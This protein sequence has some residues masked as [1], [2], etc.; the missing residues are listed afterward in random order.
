MHFRVTMY[1][2]IYIPVH[3]CICM[4]IHL[5]TYVCVRIDMHAYQVAR[6]IVSVQETKTTKQQETLQLQCFYWPKLRY[7]K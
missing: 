1:M 7:Y 4:G 5:H 6:A 2:P 3:V